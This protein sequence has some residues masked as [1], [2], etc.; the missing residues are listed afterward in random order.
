MDR[1]GLDGCRRSRPGSSWPAKHAREATM[2]SVR[3]IVCALVLTTATAAPVRAENVVRWANA[4][5][6]PWWEPSSNDYPSWNGLLQVYEGLTRS[7]ADLTLRPDLATSWALVRPD[8]WRF[9]LRQGVTFHDGAPL[10]AEDVAFSFDRAR[11]ETS[12]Y[13]STL[14]AI[15][16]V[17]AIGEH[18]VEV[19][20]KQPDLLLPVRLR[21]VAIVS[22]VWAE[23]NGA[24]L[25]AR[26]DDT[27]AY[28]F[29]H[30]D[31]TGPFT[32]ESFDPASKRA[33]L[34]RNAGWWGLKDYPHNIDRIVLTKEPD[35]ERRLRLLLDGEVDFL[36]D[37]PLDRLDRL[38]GASGIKLV[39][40][41]GLLVVF[42][43]L[44]QASAELRTS[45]IKGR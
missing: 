43:G 33:I 22:K 35:P 28:T 8:T 44:D 11:G 32:L 40:T 5:G 27:A 39:W 6:V 20:T 25:P 2:K 9:E 10:D 38:K 17:T 16:V 21:N 41:S 45:D 36:Q 18:T 13:A 7:D 12:E 24:R 3:V 26:R 42:L 1:S 14:A 29:A 23:R 4:N 19:T 37:P 15:T 30:E 31:G 34:V